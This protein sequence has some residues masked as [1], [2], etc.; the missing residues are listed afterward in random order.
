MKRLI[1]AFALLASFA[2]P[3]AASGGKET[4]EAYRERSVATRPSK[5]MRTPDRVQ[6][7]DPYWQPCN[8]SSDYGDNAC[9]G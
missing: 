6:R 9:G 2:I 7:S 5:S 3:A 4:T 8:Y 1:V